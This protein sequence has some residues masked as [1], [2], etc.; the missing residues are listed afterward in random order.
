MASPR[1]EVSGKQRRRR[2]DVVE[3]GL[4]R[5]VGWRY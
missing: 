2:P 4:L 1:R 3:Q 5:G